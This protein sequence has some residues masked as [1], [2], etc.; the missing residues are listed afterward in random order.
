MSVSQAIASICAFL[1]TIIIARYLGVSGYG[2][3][4]F[5]ISFTSILGIFLD[6]GISTYITREVAK[7]KSLIHKFVNNILVFKVLIAIILFILSVIILYLLG[8]SILTIVVTLIFSIETVFIS[9]TFLFNAIFQAIEDLKYQ[10][11]GNILNSALLLCGILIIVGFSL[12]PISVA[13]AYAVG[14]L[15]YFLC[16]LHAYRKRFGWPRFDFDYGFIKSVV[17]NSAPFGLTNFFYMIYFSID[18]VMLSYLCGDYATG[19]YRSAYNIIS[20]FTAF[21]AVYQGV[22]FPV[23]SKF[24][25]ESQDLLKVSYEMSVKYLL[26]FI[27]PITVGVFFYARP[28]MDLIYS[29]QYSLATTPMQILI[30]TVSFLFVN[31]AAATLLNAV[32]REIIVTRIYIAAAIFNVILNFILIPLYSYDGAA[33]ATVFS[34]ILIT[35]LTLYHIFKTDFKPGIGLLKSLIKLMIATIA[36]AIVLYWLNLSLW[37][38]IPIGLVVYIILLLVTRVLDDNDRY[39]IKELLKN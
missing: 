30:W 35:V 32:D 8:Y 34:E 37:L 15:G 24:F 23:M 20:I 17:I 18:I 13:I 7:D 5:A 19:L 29:N 10:S 25:K 26:L 1:W 22:A 28:L 38:A 2:I 9:M 11:I 16:M 27:L 39:I 4:S 12:G 33:I 36:L 14:F 6:F 31:G 3:V 21:F